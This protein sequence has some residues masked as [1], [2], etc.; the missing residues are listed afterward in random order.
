MNRERA[1]ISDDIDSFK[2]F[3]TDGRL[4]VEFN[5]DSN[6]SSYE[7]VYNVVLVYLTEGLESILIDKRGHT[8]SRDPD[9][10]RRFGSKLGVL[11]GTYRVKLAIVSSPDDHYEA[12]VGAYALQQGARVLVTDAPREATL[13]LDG[14]IN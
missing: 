6:S 9:S 1:L 10:A 11:L 8:V 3:F 4:T 2:F 7:E 13:W 14:K 5:N 12:A